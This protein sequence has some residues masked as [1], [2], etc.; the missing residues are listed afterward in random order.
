MTNE[1]MKEELQEIHRCLKYMING[2]T[3][4]YSC[5]T[6]DI[7]KKI[8]SMIDNYCEHAHKQYYEDAPVY[9]CGKCHMVML[10]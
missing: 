7:K 8:H 1:F 4:P 9:E 6:L 2:G 3:T 5:V 10:R